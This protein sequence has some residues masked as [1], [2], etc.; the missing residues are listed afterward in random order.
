QDRGPYGR[1]IHLQPMAWKDGW[2]LIGRPGRLAGTG[3]PVE[4]YRKPVQGYGAAAP[5]ASDDFRTPELGLQWAWSANPQPGWFAID[6]SAG[7][8]RLFTVAAP[9]ADGYVRGSPA[10][11]SQRMPASRF[12]VTTKVRLENAQEGD[13]AG[14]IVNALQYAWI[15]LRRKNG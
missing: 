9:D 14:L 6:P 15:G 8:L 11:L 2:P 3:E 1:V 7:R 5:Q 4:T 13:R 10:I 12:L